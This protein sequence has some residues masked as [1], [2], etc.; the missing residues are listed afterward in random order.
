MNKILNKLKLSMVLAIPFLLYTCTKDEGAISPSEIEKWYYYDISSGL[1]SNQIYCLAE[2]NIHNIWIGTNKGL[3]KYNGQSFQTYTAANLGMPSDTIFSVFWDSD[4]ELLIG[5]ANGFGH[6]YANQYSNVITI[7]GLKCMK[8]CED[9][10][11]YVYCATNI[12]V[13]TYHNRQFY[14]FIAV[15]STLSSE[16]GYFDDPVYDVVCDNKNYL[17]AAAYK[18][19]YLY[20]YT[21]KYF[22][23]NESLGMYDVSKLFND[24]KGNI[25][26]A[27]SK[28][29]KV[30]IYNGTK[31]VNDSIYFGYYNY[32]AF[33]QD[34]FGDFWISINDHGVLH[35]GG[36]I[37]KVYDTSHSLIKS[38][39]INTIYNDSKG[40]I[41]FGSNDK[42]L[43]YLQNIRPL[44]FQFGPDYKSKS[45]NGTIH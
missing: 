8:F 40:N 19:L 28:S 3:V 30:V 27:S 16:G 21:N 36:G 7:S 11:K 43:L 41:W 1:P 20:T 24:N 26:I 23:S 14:S 5:T 18:G 12:G 29:L 42:G 44:Q 39:D 45:N 33:T 31:F 9:K 15:D 22:S 2:D 32:K 34:Q 25:W 35:Y 37:T 13:I 6:I 4:N 38:D 17:W 10:N